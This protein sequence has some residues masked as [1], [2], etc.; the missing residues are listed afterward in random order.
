MIRTI[1]EISTFVLAL[2]PNPQES[3]IAQSNFNKFKAILIIHATE[4]IILCSERNWFVKNLTF[5]PK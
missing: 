2:K 3:S 5:L 1:I 4:I